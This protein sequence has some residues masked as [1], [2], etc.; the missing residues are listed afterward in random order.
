M[1]TGRLRGSFLI[2]RVEPCVAQWPWG[3][4]RAQRCS[5]ASQ[6]TAEPGSEPAQTTFLP[7]Q[8]ASKQPGPGELWPFE[9]QLTCKAAFHELDARGTLFILHRED[10]WLAQWH[11]MVAKDGSPEGP[12]LRPGTV[13]SPEVPGVK[14]PP[15]PVCSLCSYAVCM[16]GS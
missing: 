12:Q 6:Q 8:V 9:P 11:S 13:A 2:S 7:H 10:A 14:L 1:G 4:D 16:G 15:A 5:A 3:G